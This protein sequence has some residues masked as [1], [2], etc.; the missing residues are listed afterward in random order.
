MDDFVLVY[1][2]LR[3]FHLNKDK[4]SIRGYN[5]QVIGDA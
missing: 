2:Y 3:L 4:P 1:N 5:I